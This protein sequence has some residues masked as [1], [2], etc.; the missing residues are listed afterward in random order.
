MLLAIHALWVV[1]MLVAV[2]RIMHT[3]DRWRPLAHTSPDTTIHDIA[4]PDDLMALA[5]QYPE[6]WAQDDT[7]KVI[8]ERYEALKDWNR[9]RAALGIG[10][11]SD[12]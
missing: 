2:F 11:W 12:A 8:R 5:M 3:V 7:L 4:I 6:P 1:G 10:S 9:V